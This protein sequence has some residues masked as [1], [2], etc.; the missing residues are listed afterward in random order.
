MT[1]WVAGDW[2]MATA[3][4]VAEVDDVDWNGWVVPFVTRAQLDAIVAG[5]DLLTVWQ[6]DGSVLVTDPATE[7]GQD[8]DPIVDLWGPPDADGL[9]MLDGWTWLE[10]D[11]PTPRASSG[12]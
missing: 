8:N 11:R 3:Y 12:G 5:M 7:A 9:F 6:P 1:R 10:V 2:D 4:E